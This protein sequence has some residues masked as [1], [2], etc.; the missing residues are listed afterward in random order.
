MGFPGWTVFSALL[1]ILVFYFCY[2]EAPQ[3]ACKYDMKTLNVGESLFSGSTWPGECF[4]SSSYNEARSKFRQAVQ[5]AGGELHTYPLDVSKAHST[6][7]TDKV[8]DLS[9][10]VGVIK[11]AVEGKSK[12][13]LLHLSGV[14]GVEGFAGS[15]IQLALLEHMRQHASLYPLTT[16]DK[17]HHDEGEGELK[18]IFVHTVNPFGM[19]N[20]RRVNEN[21]VDLN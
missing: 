10:D 7:T 15:S 3:F 9:I 20:R 21:N 4:F 8:E 17:N 11:L 13:A 12:G 14:H 19:A 16:S 2:Y 18:V 5:N 1:G 6:Y